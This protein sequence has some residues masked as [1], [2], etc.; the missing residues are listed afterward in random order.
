[1]TI[2]QDHDAAV[3]GNYAAAMI[4]LRQLADGGDV[5]VWQSTIARLVAEDQRLW[6]E[7]CDRMAAE[8]SVLI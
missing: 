2:P 5:R 1:V 3:R 4:V 8:L 7:F 6:D